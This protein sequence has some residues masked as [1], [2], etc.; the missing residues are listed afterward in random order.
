MLYNLYKVATYV[1]TFFMLSSSIAFGEQQAESLNENTRK[2]LK[3]LGISSVDVD[4]TT[5]TDKINIQEKITKEVTEG[6]TVLDNNLILNFP[7]GD[8]DITEM[9]KVLP[10]VQIDESYKTS[11]QAGEIAPPK[12]SISGGKSYQNLFLFD[13][14][15]NS[16][17][18]DPDED[19]PNLL[20]DVAGHPQKFFIDAELVESVDVY[21][22]AVPAEYGGFLGGVVDV[23]LKDPE[24]WFSG[25][26]SFRHTRD[27]WTKM[28]ISSEDEYEFENSNSS[29]NQPKFK[30]N[31]YNIGLNIPVTSKLSIITSYKRIESK[32]PLK[33]LREWKEQWRLS[34]N[35][36]VQGVYKIN[37][38]SDLKIISL[39]APYSG[40]YFIK[41]AKNSDFVIKGGGFTSSIKYK[42]TNIGKEFNIQMSYSLSENSKDAPKNYY[43]WAA[44]PSKPWGYLKES[45]SSNRAISGEGG[46]GSIDKKNDELALKIIERHYPIKAFFDHNL[47]Y[48]A[49]TTYLRGSYNRLED[50][51]VYKTA[52]INPDVSC[53][54]SEGIDCI[55]GEQYFKERQI[56]Q[57]SDVNVEI[58]KIEL[59]LQDE[60]KKGMVSLTLGVRY[61]FDDYME[62]HNFSPRSL[63]KWKAYKR[64]NIVLHGGY[65]RYY[66]TSLLA[67]KLRE[68][69]KPL[70]MQRRWTW[71]NQVQDW[72]ATMT[73]GEIKYEFA[74]L[75]MPYSD[76]YAG[77]ISS[78]FLYGTL[79]AKYIERHNKDEFSKE[80][81]ETRDDGYRYYTLN[82][83]GK[84]FFRSVQLKWEKTWQNH[85]V[86]IN[87]MWQ[88]SKANT[89]NYD[90]KY[91]SD[92][93]VSQVWFEG[94]LV[95]T[96]QLP[97]RNYNRPVVV[98]ISYI[99]RFFNKITISPF[100]KYRGAYK[101]LL[102]D[103]IISTDIDG[104][105]DPVTG[106]PVSTEFSKYIVQ[107][108]EPSITIDLSIKWEE[109]IFKT[110]KIIFSLDIN[111]IL[112]K[113]EYAGSTY[114]YE[115][116]RQFW[117]GIKYEF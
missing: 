95:T 30:K 32:I 17:I 89:E 36:L 62:E 38:S 80:M 50:T 14:I 59:F 84:S 91:D 78:D 3:D 117:G 18:L 51:I 39:Y 34:E 8:G 64:W 110:Q 67:N 79:F 26:I 58:K 22:S 68:G 72:E 41:D 53:G 46:F 111:N 4:N 16:S 115:L 107:D 70:I 47:S 104:E 88:E 56:Y 33:N 77:G 65:N 108:L 94:E 103:G 13:G 82:N 40:G 69:R 54:D 105:I 12:L 73:N 90:E 1:A 6:K 99:G 37:T 5:V 20:S 83:N 85:S 10:S 2:M 42:N 43:N 92:D 61:S 109:L 98:N 21:D 52:T 45:T 9:L 102:Y 27:E 87:G 81:S 66:G 86:M 101:K 116:G 63:L 25:Y 75:K 57:E 114:E 31:H 76:E 112:D 35:Y 24:P 93:A 11:N 96:D 97:K 74:K 100:L 19:N 28:H 49:D 55:A 60:I 15:N 23:K 71:Q 7:K 29:S 48:G 44:T 106:E 113:V